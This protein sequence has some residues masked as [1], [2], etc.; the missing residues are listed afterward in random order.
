MPRSFYSDA[1]MHFLAQSNDEILG[2]LS[3]N[4]SFYLTD[5]QR[6][7]WQEEIK[8][9]KSAIS[10]FKDGW[11]VFEHTIP[12]MGRRIDTVII[13]RGI[14][15]LLE[16]KVGSSSYDRHAI[17]QVVDYALDL[18]NFHS[19]SAKV[20]LVPTLVATKGQDM[21][22]SPGLIK[23]GIFNPLLCNSNNIKAAIDFVLGKE[24]AEYFEPCDWINASYAP[25]PTIIEAA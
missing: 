22:P 8:I 7:T 21:T 20:L 24:K 18:K 10:E 1:V 3:S 4:N 13:L 25:T 16:F 6:N 5:L 19:K 23:D 9:L 17:N 11:I 2:I 15:F 12:R 14:I